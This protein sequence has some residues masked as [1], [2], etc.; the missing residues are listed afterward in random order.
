MA[1]KVFNR[2]FC[3]CRGTRHGVVDSFAL[4]IHCDRVRRVCG[5]LLSLA[6]LSL[7]GCA[8]PQRIESPTTQPIAQTQGVVGAIMQGVTG[9]NYESALS[10]GTIALVSLLSGMVIGVTKLTIRLSHQRE[11]ERIR[12]TSQPDYDSL[13]EDYRP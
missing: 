9:L 12:I 13:A 5:L 4:L 10:A 6:A 11:M 3:P 7:A 8:A 2:H 1:C